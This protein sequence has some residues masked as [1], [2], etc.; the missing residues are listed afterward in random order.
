MWVS[1]E[2]DLVAALA[3]DSDAWITKN[4]AALDGALGV[5]R[6]HIG[7]LEV[8][9]ADGA[10][11]LVDGAPVGVAFVIAPGAGEFVKR[12][13]GGVAVFDDQRDASISDRTL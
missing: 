13:V 6:R 4:R 12:R 8:R 3:T 2:T 7:S 5:I 10:E 1:A 9:G 11:I